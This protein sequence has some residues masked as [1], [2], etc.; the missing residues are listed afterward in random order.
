MPFSDIYPTFCLGLEST[1][2]DSDHST[3]A[4]WLRGLRNRK[5]R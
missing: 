4:V 5:R 3:F 1:I 2:D